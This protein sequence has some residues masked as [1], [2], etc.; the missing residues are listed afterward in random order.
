MSCEMPFA[1]SWIAASFGNKDVQILVFIWHEVGVI[2]AHHYCRTNSDP[3]LYA[4]YTREWPTADAGMAEHYIK[5]CRS[6]HSSTREGI[7]STLDRQI[8][9][10]LLPADWVKEK[11]DE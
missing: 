1:T 11:H 4:Y 10:S 8:D 7:E 2:R 6:P 5:D 9:E 3:R